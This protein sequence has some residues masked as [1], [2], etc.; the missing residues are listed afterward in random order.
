MNGHIVLCVA[1][2]R[3]LAF[4]PARSAG[5]SQPAVFSDGQTD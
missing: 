1:P 2:R 4:S 5:V 3:G